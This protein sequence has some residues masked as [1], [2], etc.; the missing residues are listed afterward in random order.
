MKLY[1]VAD[2]EGIAG[3]VSEA[4]VSGIDSNEV[5]AA[6]Q[7][8][9]EEV[10]ALCMGAIEAGVEEIYVN[11]FHGNGR[12]ILIERLPP[13]V[14]VI[15][16]DF[17]PTSGFELLD[18]TFTGLA[19]LGAHSKTNSRGGILPHT[20]SGKLSFEIFGQP[21]GEF[22]ILS[23]IAGEDRVPTILISGDSK[24]IEQVGTNLPSTHTVTTK[25]SLGPSTGLCINPAQVCDTLREEIQ[26][27][28]KKAEQIEPPQISPPIQLL[29]KC[30][31]IYCAQAI[32]WIPGLKRASDL[33]F[34]FTGEDMRQI[35]KLIFGVTTLVG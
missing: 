7:Q 33:T 32:D 16:G 2:M 11:D 5:M 22:D 17:R 8:Y 24:T 15:R 27:A 3:I 18:K 13:Q 4:Q 10:K 9:T 30:T 19:I 21:I 34:E 35:A 25:Y 26:S 29:I 20:Y 31:D 1:V 12:N 28:L 14:M 6:R 23:L